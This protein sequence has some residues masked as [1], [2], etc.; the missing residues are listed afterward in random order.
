MESL[1]TSHVRDKDAAGVALALAEL[2]SLEAE[3]GR[4]SAIHCP[5]F[6][7]KSAMFAMNY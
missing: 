5:I 2:A 7:A 6:G 4:T 1:V 3:K